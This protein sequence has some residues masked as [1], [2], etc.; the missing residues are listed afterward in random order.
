MRSTNGRAP[1]CSRNCAGS[2]RRSTS[3]TS[4]ASASRSRSRSARSR[5]NRRV[6]SSRRRA[7][8]GRPES[9]RSSRALTLP[10]NRMMPRRAGRGPAEPGAPPRR[11][12]SPTSQP[13]QE[14]PSALS[15]D[16]GRR[17]G[18]A[19]VVAGLA[20][21]AAVGFDLRPAAAAGAATVAAALWRRAA[22]LFGRRPQGCFPRWQRSR[23]GRRRA[24]GEIRTRHVRRRS[25]VRYRGR[26]TSV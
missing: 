2:R 21:F 20:G 26:R 23:R 14:A 18:D 3:P 12:V 1:P 19:F 9:V 8:P 4:P 24:R 13:P 15:P 7:S 11:Y 17:P 22:R 16:L 6:S 5:L 25:G 10:V